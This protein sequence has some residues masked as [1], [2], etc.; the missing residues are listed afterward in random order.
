MGEHVR[1][2]DTLTCWVYVRPARGP[3]PRMNK[4]GMDGSDNEARRGRDIIAAEAADAVWPCRLCLPFSDFKQSGCCGPEED[5]V[6]GG[7]GG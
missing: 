6:V 3:D 7:G 1:C 4:R 2:A 5:G